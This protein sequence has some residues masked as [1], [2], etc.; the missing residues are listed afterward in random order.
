MGDRR[1]QHGPRRGL[2]DAADQ[3]FD[4]QPR[5]AGADAATATAHAVAK[6]LAAAAPTPAPQPHDNISIKSLQ[7]LVAQL[8]EQKHNAT[9][10][11][12]KYFTKY[13]SCHSTLTA[14]QKQFTEL[15]RAHDDVVKTVKHSAHVKDLQKVAA[16]RTLL[17]EKEKAESQL[18]YHS[19]VN[20]VL[21]FCLKTVETTLLETQPQVVIRVAEGRGKRLKT[22]ERSNLSRNRDIEQRSTE[23]LALGTAALEGFQ[24]KA[25]AKVEAAAKIWNDVVDKMTRIANAS[26]SDSDD[27]VSPSICTDADAVV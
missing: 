25:D 3:R 15:C 13:Q 26:D 17:L 2:F 24:I 8:E 10:D 20:N 11:R 22:L 21:T 9:K 12:E 4:G 23:T 16:S 6:V 5:L 19:E 1:R 14:I 18:H 27:T 7:V